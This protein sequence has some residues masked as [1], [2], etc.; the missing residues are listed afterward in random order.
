LEAFDEKPF[1]ELLISATSI[2]DNE[3][4]EGA[5]TSVETLP[6]VTL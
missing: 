5:L 6:V 2:E 3:E 1:E 4:N